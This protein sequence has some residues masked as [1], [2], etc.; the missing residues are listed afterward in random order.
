M[1]RWLFP[2]FFL[3]ISTASAVEIRESNRSVRA[4]GMGNA[5]LTTVSDTDALF[6]NPAAL[7]KLSG[8]NLQLAN[9]RTGVNG[10]EIYELVQNAGD[11]SQPSGYNQF[12]GKPVWLEANGKAAIALPNFGFAVFTNNNLG[13]ELHN[14]AYPEFETHFISDYGFVLGGSVPIGSYASFGATVKRISRWGGDEVIGVGAI[15][16]G[17]GVTALEDAFK[18]KGVGY[19]MDASIMY[20]SPS[21]F[22][23]AIAIVWQDIGCTTFE[24]TDGLKA[25]PRIRDN[26][27]IGLGTNVDLP[28]FDW[29]TSLDLRHVTNNDEQVGKKIHLGTEFSLPLIDLRAGLNQGYPSYGV[30]LNLLLLRIDAAY[31][32]EEIGVYPGQT[33]SNRIQVGV[34]IDLS[35][36]ANFKFTDNSGRKRKLKQRR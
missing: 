16:S 35:F 20:T 14:P 34:S 19:G 7:A 10:L 23:P 11:L 24:K 22:S 9:L 30:G 2:L 8:F 27:S 25:P 17:S 29:A 3:W 33:A 5:Y 12:F 15:T 31:Y 28:G 18:D 1:I 6:Y 26:L 36:D 32:A 4:L 13:F 21:P